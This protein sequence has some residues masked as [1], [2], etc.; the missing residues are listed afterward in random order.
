MGVTALMARVIASLSSDI[1]EG[2][3][4]DVALE[5]LVELLNGGNLR[6]QDTL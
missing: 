2:G 6:V 1:S 4:P 5:L 3:L